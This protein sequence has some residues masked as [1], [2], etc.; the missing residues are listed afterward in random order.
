MIGMRPFGTIH[1]DI[2]WVQPALPWDTGHHILILRGRDRP[3]RRRGP[4]FVLTRLNNK[5]IRLYNSM[6]VG[7]YP[8]PVA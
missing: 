2:V 5:G 1:A 7:N 3:R 8:I 6:R 4:K